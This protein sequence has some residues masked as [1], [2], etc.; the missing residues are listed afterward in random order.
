MLDPIFSFTDP[1]LDTDESDMFPFLVKTVEEYFDVVERSGLGRAKSLPEGVNLKTGMPLDI[2]MSLL[3]PDELEKLKN[4]VTAY[5]A[6]HNS[7][8]A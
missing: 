8:E 5:L 6:K 1:I 4:Y 2:A 3:K 7:G